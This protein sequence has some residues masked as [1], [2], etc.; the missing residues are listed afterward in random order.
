MY[1]PGSR[2][3]RS[4]ANGTRTLLRTALAAIHSQNIRA[5]SKEPLQFSASMN[6]SINQIE[7]DN[8]QEGTPKNP[9][10]DSR[11]DWSNPAGQT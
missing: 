6:R 7:I 10:H 11:G 5:F 3:P 1:V 8:L 4:S 2:R 9:E